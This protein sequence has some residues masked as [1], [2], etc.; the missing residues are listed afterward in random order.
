MNFNVW[1]GLTVFGIA[2][3]ATACTAAAD[4]P[5]L[6]DFFGF[7]GLEVVKIDKGAGPV[8]VADM[9]GDGLNDLVVVNN[10]ASRI[11]VHYQKKNASPD[12]EITQPTRANQLPEHWRFRRELISVTHRVG[13]VATHDFDGDGM[14][15]LIYGG[16][17]AEIVFLRQTEPGVFQI[18]RKHSVKNLGANRNGFKI[19]DLIGDNKPELVS[20]VAGKINVWPMNGSNL[21]TAVELAAGAPMAG[22]SIEDFDGDGRPDIAG[23]IPDDPAP[24]RLWLSSI[25]GG[26]G[27]IGPQVRF[28]MPSLREFKAV[29]LPNEPAAR[30]AA[31]ERASKRIVL[32]ELAGEPIEATG[33]RDAALSVFSFT[34]PTNRKRDTEVVDIDGDGLLDLVATDTEANSL[35]VYR[36]LKGKGLQPGVS[37]PS[38][39]DIDFIAAGR[40][41]DNQY[42]TVFVLSQKEGV[43]GRCDAGPDGIGFPKPLNIPDGNTPVAMNL[44]QLEH[45]PHVAVVAKSGRD[46]MLYLIDMSGEKHT[47]SLG[48]AS[49]SP[50]TI[51][52]LD[53]DQDGKTDLLLF[54]RDKPM[55]M[56]RSTEDGFK[57][58][59]SKDMGQFGLVQAANSL[60]T[61]AMDVDGSGNAELLVA[62]KNYVRAVRYETDPGPGV[63]PGWQV[64]RQINANDSTAKL[65]SVALLGEGPNARVIAADKENGRLV[66]M[67]RY[68]PA[69]AAAAGEAAPA[70]P[71]PEWK[72]IESLKVRGF[73]I[74]QIYAGAFS[75]DGKSDI[76]AIGDDGFAVI[77]LGGERISLKQFA[78][79]RTD[80]ERR[81]QHE[82]TSGDING[83]GFTDLIS[84]DAGE[85]MCEIFTFSQAHRLLYA[86]GFKVFESK[87]F[88]SGE[89]REYQPSEAH[90]ADVTGDGANDLILL[91][92]DRVLIYPQMKAPQTAGAST[93]G[94]KLP[95][96]SATPAKRK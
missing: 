77:R 72:Q 48:S 65:V 86:V 8:V 27:K 50:D 20:L 84:L 73:G 13:A 15:D 35:V 80:Q 83:D 61:A 51:V 1:R 56:L 4:E 87:L 71:A 37:Y 2:I 75:G 53:A 88:A 60:N 82:L 57:V 74:G 12:D 43:V 47:I 10:F 79:W 16:I 89:P 33:D 85:Q 55:T 19:A 28:E 23:V 64:V 91:S 39:S 29:R 66:V 63:S 54:T 26:K 94:M 76:L 44:V 92:Q 14:L 38:L 70:A 6:A 52:A 31:I 93:T 90:V 34:D 95:A 5:S 68:T 46:Y 7:S 69:A 36:Q 78:A 45:G 18:A 49:R 32:Y 96:A 41:G 30:M 25:E 58:L 11:E 59:E 22:F 42:A 40:L 21:G 17:P 81:V 62:D 67:G 9:N 3:G 24:V